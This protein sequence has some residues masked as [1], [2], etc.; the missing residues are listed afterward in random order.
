MKP[1]RCRVR[2]RWVDLDAQGHVNNAVIVDYL[3]Q[4]RVNWLW[5]GSNAHL[6]GE[7]TMVVAHQVEYLGPVEFATAGVEVELRVG[8]VQAAEFELGYQLIQHDQVVVRARTRMCL[9]DFAAG[10]PRRMTKPERAWFADQS[11]A[12]EELRGL[13]EGRVGARA[14]ENLIEVRWSDLDR[15]GHVNNVRFFDFFAESRIRMNPDSELTTRMDAAQHEGLTWL[16]ARQDVAYLGQV[17]LRPQPYRV[18]TGVLGMGRTSVT[19][20]AELDDPGDEVALARAHTV[21][22]SADATGRPVPLPDLMR[23][24]W[25]RWPAEPV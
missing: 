12:L 18:R 11:V 19:L 17:V 24:A 9:F 5:S 8:R 21:L 4:A 2:Q 6:L 20:V 25:I 1:F 15:Y 13:A 22:V 14:H 10:S 7:S 3:Q 16:V 23:R